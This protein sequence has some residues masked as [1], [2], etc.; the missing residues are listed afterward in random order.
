L[1]DVNL[2]VTGGSVRVTVSTTVFGET[3]V[4]GLAVIVIVEVALG[5]VSVVIPDPGQFPPGEVGVGV[6]VDVVCFVVVDG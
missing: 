3:T 6:G 1:V 5:N 2:F 4:V